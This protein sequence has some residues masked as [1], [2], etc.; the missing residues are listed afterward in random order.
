MGVF[1]ENKKYGG[2]QKRKKESITPQ[3]ALLGNDA[4]AL[5]LK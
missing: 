4:H 3:D 5:D 2:T 1:F